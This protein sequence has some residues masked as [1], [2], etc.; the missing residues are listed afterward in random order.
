[1]P[2]LFLDHKLPPKHSILSIDGFSV[3]TM[4]E[5]NVP[6]SKVTSDFV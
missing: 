4:N 2:I 3:S 6:F 1:M 5:E